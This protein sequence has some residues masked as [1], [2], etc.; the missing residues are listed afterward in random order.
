MADFVKLSIFGTVFE[1]TTRYVDLQPVGMG[2]FGLVCSAKDQLTS[3]SVAI[4]KIMKPFSTPVLSKRTYRELKL[5]KHIRH[6]NVSIGRG[7][8]T[9]AGGR[10]RSGAGSGASGLQSMDLASFAARVAQ[11]QLAASCCIRHAAAHARSL[12][13]LRALPRVCGP[14]QRG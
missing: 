11:L 14:S 1:V 4:K 9:R 13:G 7:M 5:L 2:A 6:E 12:G 3:T 8:R 10:R